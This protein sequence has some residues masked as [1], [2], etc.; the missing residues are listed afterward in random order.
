MDVLKA[1]AVRT[2]TVAWKVLREMLP[3]GVSSADLTHRPVWRDWMSDWKEGASDADYWKQVA[4]AAELIVQLVGNDPNRWREVLDKLQSVPEPQRSELVDQLRTLPV[5]EIDPEDR[6]RFAEHLRKT[7]QRHRDCADAWWALPA[8]S[9]DA[10]EQVLPRL[11]PVGICERY[12][13]L[14]AEWPKL[15]GFRDKY[16]EMKEEIERRRKDA[17]REI[18]D[19][20]GFDG[21]LTLADIAESPGQVGATLAQTGLVPDARIL[22]DLLRSSNAKHQLLAGA[23]ARGRIFPDHWDWVRSLP[24]DNWNAKEAAALLSQAGLVREAWSIA[25]SLGQ[26]VSREYWKT[27]LVHVGSPLDRQQ[28]EFACEQLTEAGRPEAAISTLSHVTFREVDVSSSIVLDV[29]AEYLK[30]AHSDPDKRLPTGTLHIV[31]ELFGW[32]QKTI[33]FSNEELVRRL[34]QLE[35]AFGLDGSGTYGARPKT[36]IRCLSDSPQF[37]AELIAQIFR[38]K[39]EQASSTA[40]TEEQREKALRGYRLLM[41]WDQVPGAKP[42]GSIDEEQLLRWL[43]SARSLCRQS[44]HLEIADSKI[45]EML[46]NWPQPND[47]STP[48]PCEEICDA[49][50]EADSDDL[51]HGFQIGVLN[52]RGVTTRSPLDGGDLERREAAKYRRWAEGRDV[53]WPRTAASLRSVVESYESHAKREDAEAAERAQERH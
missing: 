7:I 47:D 8:D 11:Q 15:E 50:E 30:W 19:Q 34:A 21:I 43:E 1:L 53:N 3:E 32:L 22:P 46:A 14:F 12:A 39:N 10:L 48:W 37:F 16:Q 29:L 23:Y 35:W 9:V 13:W 31:H 6:R 49:I 17:L 27:V 28:L 52:S 24:L 33:P 26:D 25:E 18:V 40:P 5:D 2:P 36:L 38:S 41:G 45:G 42:D 51:D 44:G 4:T 20:D